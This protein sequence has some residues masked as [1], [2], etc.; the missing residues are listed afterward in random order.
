MAK[1]RGARPP[2]RDFIKT[3]CFRLYG[4]DEA[5]HHPAIKPCTC[6]FQHVITRHWTTSLRLLT[7]RY[8]IT[9]LEGGNQFLSEKL[10]IVVVVIAV[11]VTVM[12][13]MVMIIMVMIIMVMAIMIT[14]GGLLMPAH[15]GFDRDGD[16]HRPGLFKVE[17]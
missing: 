13:I 15:H 16:R 17:G 12:I 8:S 14:A 5:A 10:M 11:V 7:L 9:K 6:C 4:G 2:F 3:G 1:E